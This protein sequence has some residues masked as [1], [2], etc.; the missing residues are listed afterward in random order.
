MP[1]IKPGI[2]ILDDSSPQ[3]VK[4]VIAT[5]IG[6]LGST[7]VSLGSVDGIALGDYVITANIDFSAGITVQEI[8]ANNAIRF[9]ATD[10][11]AEND[12]VAF[13]RGLS[14]SNLFN[15]TA[16]NS[17][18]L[19]GQTADR[20][21]TLSTDQWFRRDVAV[22]G[23]VY[24]GTTTV[25]ASGKTILWQNSKDFSIVNTQATGNID[26]RTLTTGSTAP[27]TVFRIN[28][29]T[30]LA[31]VIA[32]PT[33]ESGIATKRYV[34]NAKGFAIAAIT[35]N[36][37]TLK[38]GA[39]FGRDN[40]GDVSTI[41]DA[42]ALSISDLQDALPYKAAI[43]SQ[44][45]TGTPRA[46]TPASADNSTK[47]ATTAFV[48]G[49]I[50]T[51][52]NDLQDAIDNVSAAVDARAT[53][54]SP[55]LSG[56]PLTTA[57]DSTDNSRRI[58][59]TKFVRDR[60]QDVLDGL[61][62]SLAGAAPIN[63]PALQGIPTAPTTGNLSYTLDN[64]WVSTKDLVITY[65]TTNPSRLATVGFVANMIATMP[66]PNLSSL[67]PL[68]NPTFTGTPRALTASSTTSTTQIATTEFVKLYAPVT[69]VN[70]KTGSVSLLV[71][72]IQ[73]A[74]PLN[75][76][77]FT[78]VPTLTTAPDSGDDSLK[79]PTTG[80]VRDITDNLAPAAGPTFSGTVTVPNPANNSDT[81]VAAST[82][83][84]RA[85]IAEADVPKW[86]GSAK[87]I[88]NRAPNNNEG[89][90]GDLWFQYT[91]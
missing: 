72:D 88:E 15:G 32:D 26:I 24:V 55:D 81:T 67:A 74:A 62:G 54:N 10:L 25:P 7:T 86:N 82:A 17:Q 59:T 44:T 46:P 65:G 61:A 90:N 40:F 80:W 57:P 27:I 49:E 30:G 35:A 45:F 43:D 3:V 20:F 36:V 37:A 84:V 50:T 69:S 2:T 77:T 91:A 73:G 14:Q 13:Q 16:T 89:A 47:I 28:G 71:G 68:A 11:I 18:R 34:D 8:F 5:A 9:N 21:A 22:G 41:L 70:S 31:N 38:N 33:A 64:N 23:N 75:S 76:P 79:I 48:A 1:T 58:A 56:V 63:S 78:G 39:G 6:A 83:W 66:Y 52:R 85:R 19:N 12:T 42:Y 51:A 4:S 60:V 87:F 29:T 53:I